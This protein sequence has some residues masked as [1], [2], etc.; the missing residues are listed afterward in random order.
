MKT[1]DGVSFVSFLFFEL[2]PLRG[3]LDAALSRSSNLQPLNM[4]S[5][6]WSC[7]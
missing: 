5:K 1:F 2:L 7:I 3:E 4:T 6:G